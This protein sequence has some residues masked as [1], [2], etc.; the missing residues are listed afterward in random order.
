V[1]GALVE[2]PIVDDVLSFRLGARYALHKRLEI[3][4]SIPIVAT[5]A[6]DSG[7]GG[8]ALGDGVVAAPVGVVPEGPITLSLIPWINLPTGPTARYLGDGRVGAGALAAAT[9][10]AGPVRATANLGVDGRF[11]DGEANVTPGPGL[12]GGLTLGGALSPDF[13]VHAEWRFQ[14][15]LAGVDVTA[16]PSAWPGAARG[17]EIGLAARYRTGTWLLTG[18]VAT[19]TEPG[20]ASARLRVGFGVARAWGVPAESGTA[21]V[22]TAV[23]PELRVLGYG[24]KPVPGAVVR[25]DGVAAAVADSSGLADL[26]AARIRPGTEL[27]IE[28]PGYQS[29]TA[30]LRDGGVV[31]LVPEPVAFN[32]SVR[33]EQGAALPATLTARAEGAASVETPVNAGAARLSLPPGTWTLDVAAPGYGSQQRSVAVPVGGSLGG[34]EVILLPSVGDR[35][36]AVQVT[37]AEGQPVEAATVALG[38]RPLGTTGNGGD[39]RVSGLGATPLEVR[40]EAESFRESVVSAI[41]TVEGAPV[42]LVLA[43]PPGAVLVR[44]LGADGSPVRGATARFAGPDRLGPFALGDRGDRTFVLR[45][46]AWQA[47]V[48]HPD[49][50]V[51]QRPVRVTDGDGQLQRVTVVLRPP[52]SG[53][54][55][56]VVR[57]VDPDGEPIDGAEV[58]L[59]GNELGTTSSGG[60]TLPG[61]ALGPRT[62]RLGGG[63]LQTVEQSLDLHD[64]LQEVLLVAG[65]KPGT[66]RV[67][68]ASPLGMVTDGTARF[69]GTTR[70][71]SDLGPDGVETV[72]LDPGSWQALITSPRW[73]AQQRAVRVPADGGRLVRVDVA[74][75][76]DAGGSANLA[77]EVRDPAGLPVPNARIQLDGRDLG[78][79]ST[80]GTV[81]LEGIDPGTRSLTVTAAPYRT[82]QRTVSVPKTGATASVDLAWGVGAVQVFVT[83]GGKPVSDAV[84]RMGGPRF[85][86]STPVQADGSR[87]F[88]L[89]PGAWQ[90]LASSKAL[91]AV[92]APLTVPSTPGLTVVRVALDAPAA[93]EAQ[94]VVRVQDPDGAPVRGASLRVDEGAPVPIVGGVAVL[95]DVKPGEH[96]IVSVAPDH[97]ETVLEGVTLKQGLNERIVPMAFRPADLKVEVLGPD[98]KPVVAKVSLSGPDEIPERET[99]PDGKASLKLRPGAWRV[100]ASAPDLGVRSAEIDLK[101]GE[102]ARTVTIRLKTAQVDVSADAVALRGTI[103]FDTGKSTLKAESASLLDEVA[104]TLL[105]RPDL[106]KIEV[107]GH[108]DPVGGVEV[109]LTLSRERAVAVVEALVARGVAPERLVARGYGPTRPRATNESEEGRAQN[110]RVEFVVETTQ[111]TP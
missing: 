95:S 86:P 53:T 85:V 2:Q 51:Q 46:G 44:V 43:R 61:L 9:L 18:G 73:G 87:L 23:P 29:V 66:V 69:V 76:D 34:F 72:H 22:S 42:S 99:G 60:L 105:A 39:L 78:S 28:A 80:G 101:P 45:A 31:T 27:G 19:A 94:V 32:V 89:E 98:G 49:Y 14:R 83:H 57:A 104:D 5:S 1:S 35:S 88:A 58:A 24:D 100:L 71:T 20:F 7:A 84:V 68:A 10:A 108:T 93:D 90:V 50:G 30:R 70:L 3:A 62:L 54:A 33:S 21:E 11:F 97:Q 13:G 63:H 92:Q 110:R 75:D 48:S 103:P 109:N 16:P 79:T 102:T 91:G 15:R 17:S 82:V 81:T 6:G 107:Q 106:V 55:N 40:V 38:G 25:V 67:T 64:G 74:F 59:D 96:R 26:R 52:E 12:L 56:L 47:L 4:A 111:E 36:L 77:V 37:G 8:P 41:P 65:Y